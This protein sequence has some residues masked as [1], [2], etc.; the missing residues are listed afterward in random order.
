MG[1]VAEYKKFADDCRQPARTMRKP[2]YRQQLEQMAIA[3]E[4]LALE[5]EAQLKTEAQDSGRAA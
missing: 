4:M 1:R 5:D 3:W 2:E